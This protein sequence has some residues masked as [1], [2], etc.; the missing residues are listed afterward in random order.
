ME[1]CARRESELLGK[2]GEDLVTWQVMQIVGG[3]VRKISLEIIR[4][5][6]KEFC[7]IDAKL[8][9]AVGVPSVAHSGVIGD[10][11]PHGP[12]KA[13]GVLE[14]VV[15]VDLADGGDGIRDELLEL[16]VQELLLALRMRLA[17]PEGAIA[18]LDLLVKLHGADVA[19]VQEPFL[20][21]G[22]IEG[23]DQ[24]GE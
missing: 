20:E 13:G 8:L 11:A 3:N 4:S 22:D 16:D 24:T 9:H 19:L 15:S 10:V 14:A 6:G 18:H 23:V 1:A 21:E 7:R 17:E 12:F 2:F 5:L